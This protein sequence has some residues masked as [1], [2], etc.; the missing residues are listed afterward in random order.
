MSNATDSVKLTGKS[1]ITVPAKVVRQLGLERGDFLQYTVQGRALVLT[2]RPSVG[3]RLKG[4]WS[5]N[6]QANTGPATDDSIK[7]TLR[8]YH[9]KQTDRP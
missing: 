2:P 9:T 8:D 5:E 7:K 1:Q 3:Q 4:I 6:I